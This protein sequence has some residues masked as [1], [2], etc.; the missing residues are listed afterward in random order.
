VKSRLNG[1]VLMGYVFLFLAGITVSLI[2]G[3][4]LVALLV[5]IVAM[6]F[7]FLIYLIDLLC[8]EK[9]SGVD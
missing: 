9:D 7:F 6:A 1:K 2:F 8:L 3:H 5:S 4:S